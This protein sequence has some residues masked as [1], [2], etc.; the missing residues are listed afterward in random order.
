MREQEIEALLVSSH[1]NYRYISGFSG[2]ACS[3]LITHHHA[4]IFT[5]FRYYALAQRQAPAFTLHKLTPDAPLSD[6]L[7]GIAAELRV[8]HIAFEAHTT[9]VAYYNK[10]RR[11]LKEQEEHPVPELVAVTNLIETL[12]EVKDSDEQATIRRAV[13]IT[14][15]SFEAILPHLTPDHT[16]R[17]VAWMLEVAMREHGADGIAFPII[18]AAGLNSALPHA[19][20][21]EATLG[22]GCPIII[23]MGAVYRGYHADMTRTVVLGEPDAR[24]WEVYQCVQAAQQ[25][26]IDT[27]RPGMQAKDA[28]ATARDFIAAAGFGDT[29]GHGLGHGVGL[30]VHEAP[31]VSNRYEQPLHAGSV[32]S[33]EP[34]IYLEEWGGVR[35]EDLV[36]LHEYGCEVLSHARQD[37]VV[38][39]VL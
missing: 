14:D 5:D 2:T 9:T 23:D 38:E 13:A 6:I 17:Q 11:K 32:F 16:E 30:D 36:R 1:P 33:V 15:A 39:S 20:P 27:I 10:L 12:R 19:Q 25:K 21:G 8:Q 29:F 34:G 26:A 7:P 37:P 4:L 18:V 28:D 24:F 31:H 35:I 3:L 22:R